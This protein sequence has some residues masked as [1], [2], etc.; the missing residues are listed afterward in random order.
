[1]H[2]HVELKAEKETGAAIR[3]LFRGC[4]PKCSAGPVAVLAALGILIASCIPGRSWPAWTFSRTS[5]FKPGITW[6][7]EN[8]ESSEKFLIE[9]MGAVG[10]FLDFDGDGLL[11]LFFVRARDAEGSA[12][13]ARRAMR[14]IAIWG[15]N[16]K[17]ADVDRSGPV[18][19]A[20][21]FYGMGVA[22]P[23]SINDGYP[24]LFHYGLPSCRPFH[25]NPRRHIHGHYEKAGVKNAGRWAA[26]AAW[27]DYD[28]T[29]HLDL[30][31]S[32]LRNVFPY[33]DSHRLR[34][35]GRAHLLRPDGLRRGPAHTLS[36]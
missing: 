32:K 21:P 23:I 36:Q 19:R 26:S 35:Q 13:L 10:A 3:K 8:G 1:M 12:W 20:S 5:P 15:G 33:N 17:F 34:I 2:A 30:F 6:R 7:H 31:V 27:I 4:R 16:G 25:N 24:D 28:A 29:G 18:W 14:S 11:D 22:V 9:A